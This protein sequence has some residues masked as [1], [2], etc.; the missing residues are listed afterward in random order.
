MEICQLDHSILLLVPALDM[1]ASFKGWVPSKDPSRTCTL[2]DADPE[3]RHG[4]RT[5][6]LFEGVVNDSVHK[7][8][9][10]G[11]LFSFLPVH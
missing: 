1:C 10:K 4:Q 6:Q 9:F 8:A 7:G 3:L 11:R 5:Q 2:N